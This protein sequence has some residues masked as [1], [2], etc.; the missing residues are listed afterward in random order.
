MAVYKSIGFTAG[1]LRLA[2]TLRFGV[3][4]ASGAA[5][6]VLLSGVFADRMIASVLKLFG[7]GS[8]HSGFGPAGSV[9]PAGMVT[10]L[11]LL[12]AYLVSGRVK[13]AELTA[14]MNDYS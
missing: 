8:F 6:G 4:V 10:G 9:P 3:V 2:F 13:K 1:R 7:I 14:L 5:V 12:F 11:F